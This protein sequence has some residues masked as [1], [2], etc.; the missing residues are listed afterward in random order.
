[1]RA[2]ESQKARAFVLAVNDVEGSLRIAET[3]RQNFPDL[4]IYARA[5]DRTHVHRLMDLGVTIIERETFLSAL[6]LTR[7]LLRGL[8]LG[9][10]QVKRLTETF[11]RLDEKRLYQDYQ[12]YTDLE[13]V[14]ANAL[15][16]S[17]GA[18]GA[19]RPRRG[20]AQASEEEPAFIG[21]E[22]RD[23]RRS[24]GLPRKDG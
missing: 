7:K 8:G 15:L 2:A 21:A 12:Y 24:S 22:R 11:K 5:R 17:E 6:E 16:A 14:R 9:E 10:A 13:K 19:V 3:V 4:P 18:R 20:R 1:M 23:G